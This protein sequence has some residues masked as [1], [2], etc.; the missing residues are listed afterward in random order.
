MGDWSK[1]LLFASRDMNRNGWLDPNVANAAFEDVQIA[2][3]YLDYAFEVVP[4]TRDACRALPCSSASRS[5][6]IS[7]RSLQPEYAL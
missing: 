1:D 5:T 7:S 6:A 3:M 2:V 4:K